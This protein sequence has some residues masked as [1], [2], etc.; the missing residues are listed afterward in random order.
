MQISSVE[1]YPCNQRQEK[2]TWSFALA[3]YPVIE[4]WTVAV[5]ADD[6]TTGLGYAQAI[7]HIGSSYEGVKAGLDLLKP[8]LMGSEPAA[9]RSHP[10]GNGCGDRRQRLDQGRH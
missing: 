7:P 1:F 8:C 4:G 2:Q 6:G 5:T 9:H 3:T 10:R